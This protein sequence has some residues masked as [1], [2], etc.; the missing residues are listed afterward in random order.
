MLITA[1]ISSLVA[2][3]FSLLY[4]LA[5]MLVWVVITSNKSS[6][7]IFKNTSKVFLW[8]PIV[9]LVIPLDQQHH[10]HCQYQLFFPFSF[11]FVLFLFL[12][13]LLVLFIITSLIAFI[14]I[15]FDSVNGEAYGV[16][17]LRFCHL[18]H[19][20]R[21]RFWFISLNRW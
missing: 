5:Y 4:W 11:F 13:K 3:G 7:K 18:G 16:Q 8:S 12:R 19:H 14:K 9:L 20:C 6:L 21:N 17:V 15:L 2:G 1:L 10:E